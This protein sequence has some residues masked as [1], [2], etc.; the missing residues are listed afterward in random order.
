MV[1]QVD[2]HYARTRPTRLWARLVSYALF[3]GRPLTTRGRWINPLL[4]AMFF[5]V[6]QTPWQPRP[7]KP[8]FVLGT[9]RSGTTILGVVLSMHREVGFLN[10]PKL[11]WHSIH[12][13]EDLIGSYAREPGRYRLTER[14]STPQRQLAARRLFSFYRAMT[15]SRVVVDKYPELIFRIPFVK[16]IFPEA[17]FIVLVRNGWDTCRSIASWSDRLGTKTKSGEVH[18]WWGRNRQKWELLV[19]QLVPEHPDLAPHA[20]ELRTWTDQRNMAAVEWVITMREALRVMREYPEDV[21]K[22]TYEE[23]CKRPEIVVREIANFAGIDPDDAAFV[24]YAASVLKP[25]S[26]RPASS[27]SK[28]HPVLDGPFQA[29]MAALGYGESSEGEGR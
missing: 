17:K 11:L 9:G 5:I 23:L 14:D 21:L 4:R 12:P 15:G 16:A 28:L 2:R 13:E 8:V 25:P 26:E 24:R 29:T 20:D 22:V 1:A 27:A 7:V 10:E 3:E 19:E 18:D 6:K